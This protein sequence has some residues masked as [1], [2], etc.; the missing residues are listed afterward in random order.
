MM[1]ERQASIMQEMR[2]MVAELTRNSAE[3]SAAVRE[4]PRGAEPTAVRGNSAEDSAAVKGARVGLNPLLY[5]K[6]LLLLLLLEAEREE[7]Q[8]QQERRRL[9]RMPRV[10]LE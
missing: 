9:V 2:E 6:L 4:S 10:M 5:D 3:D 7:I 8:Q 1:E